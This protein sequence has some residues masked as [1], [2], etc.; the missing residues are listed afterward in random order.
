VATETVPG[1]LGRFFLIGCFSGA[2]EAEPV[3]KTI[4]NRGK[5]FLVMSTIATL[6]THSVSLENRCTVIIVAQRRH[7]QYK[8]N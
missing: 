1:H 3:K 5:S 4:F 7:R 8:W 2:M 6:T